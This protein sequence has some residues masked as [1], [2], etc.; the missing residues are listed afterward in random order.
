[1]VVVLLWSVDADADEPLFI[2]QE[3]GPFLGHQCAVGLDAVGDDFAAGIA[4]LQ[5]HGPPIEGERTHHGL[6]AV[7]GE[8]DLVARLC[9]DVLL[10]EFLQQ[11]FAHHVAR[12]A[13]VEVLFLEVVAIVARQ[14]AV[15]PDGL[16]HDVE[17]TGEGG[18]CHF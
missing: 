6:A 1:V 3:P 18:D 9:T 16:E 7:P 5:F 10:D 14:V 8:E 13:V 4:P 12:N 2:V 11:G 15:G 17:R